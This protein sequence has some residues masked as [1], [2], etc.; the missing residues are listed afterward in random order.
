MGDKKRD[1]DIDLYIET[2]ETD[3]S[4]IV[5]SKLSFLVVLNRALGE[6][7]IDV[8]IHQIGSEFLPIHQMAKQT[9]I[10]LV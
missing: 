1:G 8:V 7:K 5:A 4:K 10:R 2:T 6:Q 9:G 3:V